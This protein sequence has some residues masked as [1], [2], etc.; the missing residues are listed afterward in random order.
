LPVLGRVSRQA[1]FNEFVGA[2]G[3][4][5]CHVS[6]KERGRF[7][8]AL[9]DRIMTASDQLVELSG[10]DSRLCMRR[11][12]EEW[13]PRELKGTEGGFDPFFSSDGEWVAYSAPPKGLFR[14]PVGGGPPPADLLRTRSDAIREGLT[15]G[16]FHDQ[17]W[18][19]RFCLNL[20]PSPIST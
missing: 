19:S 18:T 6:M 2:N 3:N 16:R 17:R 15:F 5:N 9:I 8:R 14:V 11:I 12:G 4:A 1:G 7:V 13:E 10:E 20:P